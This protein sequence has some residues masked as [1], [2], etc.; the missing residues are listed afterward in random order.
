MR[1]HLMK[2]EKIPRKTVRR[3]A[4][5]LQV[6]EE[7]RRARVEIASSEHLAE[8]CGANAHQVRKDLTYFGEFGIRGVG[9]R[10]DVLAD[11]LRQALGIDRLWNVALVGSGLLCRAVLG[12]EGYRKMGFRIVSVFDFDAAVVGQAL[13]G[14]EVQ[15]ADRLPELAPAMGVEIGIVSTSPEL[16]QTAANLLIQAGVRAIVN[17]TPAVLRAPPHVIV[18][19]ADLSLALLAASFD[20]TREHMFRAQEA[21]E[22]TPSD[23][24]QAPSPPPR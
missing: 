13:E 23:G 8:A 11:L 10:V 12:H 9:Y 16:A 7:L 17:F 4:M 15:P 19:P 20:I 3:L 2:A 6:L 14:V 22:A 1:L 21:G 18:E 24:D 5:Y